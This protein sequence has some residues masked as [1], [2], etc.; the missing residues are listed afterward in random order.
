MMHLKYSLIMCALAALFSV[1]KGQEIQEQPG[2]DSIS[3]YHQVNARKNATDPNWKSYTAKTVDR[4]PEFAYTS[5]PETDTFG[6]WKVDS[7]TGSGFFSV[8]KRGDRWWIIDP[9]GNPFIHKGVAVFRP[10]RSENQKAALS[11]KYG[12]VA[13]WVN[14]ESAFLK[15]HGFNGTG[16]WSN[17]D[18]MREQE[19]PLVYTLIVNPM[20]AYKSRHRRKYGKYEQAGWQGYRYDLAMVFDPEFDAFVESEVSKIAKYK[21]DKYLLGYYTDNELPWVNDALDRHLKCLG[22]KEAG[23]LAKLGT[24][25]GKAL[26]H[27]RVVHKRRRLRPAQPHRRWLECA[28]TA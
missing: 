27:H 11:S 18:L 10:G 20:G 7:V 9:E 13:D 25:V 5:D 24:M 15:E 14:Q 12:S 28:H 16:A 3:V 19:A 6:G 2:F 22:E 26:S 1:S 23:Y 8:E 21:E 4:L 17:V